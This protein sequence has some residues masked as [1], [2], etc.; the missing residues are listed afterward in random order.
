MSAKITNVL[1]SV[2]AGLLCVVG[3]FGKMQVDELQ[4]TR[5]AMV[6]IQIDQGHWEEKINH[7]TS[8]IEDH[9]NRLRKIEQK[10]SKM[11]GEEKSTPAMFSAVLGGE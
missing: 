7:N 11:A 8:S 2:V 5:E 3:Y 9:E 10:P 1:L 4:K 6:N